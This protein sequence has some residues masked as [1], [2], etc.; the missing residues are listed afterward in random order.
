V[1]Y[2]NTRSAASPAAFCR[3]YPAARLPQGGSHPPGARLENKEG[4]DTPCH[5]LYH[6]LNLDA[7]SDYAHNK[8]FMWVGSNC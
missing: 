2:K 4:Q 7:G 5:Y 8:K 6:L 1:L 3:F